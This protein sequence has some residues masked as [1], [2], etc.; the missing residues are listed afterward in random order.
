MAKELSLQTFPTDLFVKGAYYV[1]KMLHK[2]NGLYRNNGLL[3]ETIFMISL[4][5]NIFVGKLFETSFGSNI[6][7]TF[8]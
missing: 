6:L 8:T 3:I 2:Y 4:K 7:A 5:K 1:V